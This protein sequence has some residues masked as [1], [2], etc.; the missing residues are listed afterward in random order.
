M[1]CQCTSDET[2]C[3]NGDSFVCCVSEVTQCVVEAMGGLYP[4]RCCPKWTVGCQVGSVGCC[5][6]ARPWQ[7]LIGPSDLK[8]NNTVV[9]D[10]DNKP[11]AA[12]SELVYALFVTGLNKILNALTMTTDGK[13]TS[14]QPVTGA[15]AE[16]YARWYGQGTPLFPFDGKR[17]SFHFVDAANNSAQT[18]LY[19]IDAQTGSSSSKALVSEIGTSI[20]GYPVGMQWLQ[21]YDRMLFSTLSDDVYTYYTVSV[22]TGVASKL[23]AVQRNSTQGEADPSYYAGYFSGSGLDGKSIYRL[24]YRQVTT[25]QSF[26]FFNSS[27]GKDGGTIFTPMQPPPS[28]YDLY[29]FDRLAATEV[30]YS[31]AP[32]TTGDNSFAV[33]KWNLTMPMTLVAQLTNA[34]PPVLNGLGTLGYVG[35][36]VSPYTY[37]AIVMSQ[38]SYGQKWSISSIDLSNNKHE[39]NQFDP[40]FSMPSGCGISGIGLTLIV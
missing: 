35:T 14:T 11:R 9:P 30:Y 4:S 19:T 28:S 10:K 16:W 24:G 38:T 26:G 40:E 17:L 31:L 37:I 6:P 27:L 2:C 20:T 7:R 39:T 21:D 3:P 18:V 13:R 32:S 5:D 1:P 12:P 22:V 36:A 33:F 15:A 23:G 25:Q 8:T 34:H 29:S